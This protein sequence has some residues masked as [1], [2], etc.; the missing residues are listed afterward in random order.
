VE[1]SCAISQKMISDVDDNLLYRK[2][3]YF[4][5]CKVVVFYNPNKQTAVSKINFIAENDSVTYMYDFDTVEA[6]QNWENIVTESSK[7]LIE[8]YYEEQAIKYKNLGG[9]VH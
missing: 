6:Q 4:Y 2:E 7:K 9:K 3:Y 8:I 1:R 5:N